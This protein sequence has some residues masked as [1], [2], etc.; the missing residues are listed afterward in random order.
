MLEANK[1]FCQLSPAALSALRL[2]AQEQKFCAGQEIFWAGDN[3]NGVY[4]VRD[5]L[6][7]NPGLVDQVTNL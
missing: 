6:V 3:G 5:G 7:E 1:L 4:V 2:I